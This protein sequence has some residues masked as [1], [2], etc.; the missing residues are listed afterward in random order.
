MITERWKLQF[1]TEAFNVLNRAN[2]STPN[3]VFGGATFGRITTT[4]NAAR[5]LQ[6][7]LKLF[8]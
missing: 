6:L 3:G 7:S 4:A 2:F 8:F 5:T 1:R